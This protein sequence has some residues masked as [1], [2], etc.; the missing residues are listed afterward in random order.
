MKNMIYK[1][2]I[3]NVVTKNLFD[4][5]KHNKSKKH[6]EKVDIPIISSDENK[7]SSDYN[8]VIRCE[9]CQTMSTKHNI[10][11]HYKRCVVKVAKDNEITALKKQYIELKQ[12]K[13]KL[14]KEKETLEK[15]TK[16][17]DDDLRKHQNFIKQIIEKKDEDIKRKDLIL[18]GLVKLHGYDKIAP[19]ELLDT[20]APTAPNLLEFKDFDKFKTNRG[21]KDLDD[22][23][24]AVHYYQK[25]ELH[26]YIS[27]VIVKEYFK[28]KKYEQSLHVTDNQRNNY[29]IRLG[30]TWKDDKKGSKVADMLI[31]P[32]LKNLKI[33]LEKYIEEYRNKPDEYFKIGDIYTAEVVLSNLASCGKILTLIDSNKLKPSVAK[34][35]KK[36]LNLDRLDL[37]KSSVKDKKMKMDKEKDKY[38]TKRKEKRW[39]KSVNK[40]IRSYNKKMQKFYDSLIEDIDKSM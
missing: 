9:Y 12:D 10:S 21:N 24:I 36:Y 19:K 22:V 25:N 29:H 23:Q 20:F 17:K 13:E 3:C 6:C 18:E 7:I 11:R 14:Q 1:C 16:L 31:E 27:E 15:Q 40:K 32:L 30:D 39:T 34:Y 35:L 33:S 37:I 28:E 26:K 38:D 8:D 2:T 5:N 4:F